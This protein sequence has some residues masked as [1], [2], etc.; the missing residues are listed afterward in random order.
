M[1]KMPEYITKEQAIN[2]VNVAFGHVYDS[3]ST[4]VCLVDLQNE[5]IMTIEQNTEPADV[6][7]VVH[8]QWVITDEANVCKPLSDVNVKTRNY[9]EHDCECSNCGF[10][11]GIGVGQIKQAKYCPGC[12]A[13]MDGGVENA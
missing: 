10:I 2:V 8:A 9:L 11:C 7:P 4:T 3:D 6:A 12:G 5:I 1:I 13:R